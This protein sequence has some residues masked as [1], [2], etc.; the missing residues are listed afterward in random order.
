M[1]DNSAIG[2]GNDME[3]RG[4]DATAQ[5]EPPMNKREQLRQ[6]LMASVAPSVDR[7]L[8]RGSIRILVAHVPEAHFGLGRAVQLAIGEAGAHMY[9]ANPAWPSSID[10]ALKANAHRIG[11]SSR[12]EEA[13]P[14]V[15]WL[16]GWGSRPT[17]ADAMLRRLAPIVAADET[18][19]LAVLNN[20]S[21]IPIMFPE[22]GP[23]AWPDAEAFASHVAELAGTHRGMIDLWTSASSGLDLDID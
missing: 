2:V 3:G 18:L 1:I 14:A 7:V 10:D 22:H 12:A 19:R 6:G 15:I 21:A 23:A 9:E 8:S 20:A 13:A 5:K 17:E 11:R 16:T 4:F